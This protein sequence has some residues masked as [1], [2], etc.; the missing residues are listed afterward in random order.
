MMFEED[1]SNY[2]HLLK[3]NNL[4]LDGLVVT[5]LGA[6]HKYK[7]LGLELIGDYSLNIYNHSAA[8]FFEKQGLSMATFQWK[9]H[10]RC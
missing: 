6:I 10:F 3:E 2:N 5:N 1:F 7:I 8:S 4:G 9:H